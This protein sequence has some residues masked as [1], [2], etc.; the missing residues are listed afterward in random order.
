MRSGFLAGQRVVIG[1]AERSAMGTPEGGTSNIGTDAVPDK[2][3]R[4]A[5]SASLTAPRQPD[6]G[7]AAIRIF[8]DLAHDVKAVARQKSPIFRA[9]KTGVIER[10]ALE[11]AHRNADRP[12]RR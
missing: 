12:G 10:I 11:L 3:G 7:A 1:K 9:I 5:F 6:G 4:A 8:R 2:R